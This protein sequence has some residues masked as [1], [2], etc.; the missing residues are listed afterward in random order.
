[1]K[2]VFFNSIGRKFIETMVLLFLPFYTICQVIQPGTIEYLKYSNGVNGIRLGADLGSINS[3]EI[4]FLDGNSNLD[5]DSCLNFECRDTSMLKISNDISLDLIGIRTYKNK[6]INIYLFFPR[7]SS[8]KILYDFLVSYGNFTYRP[9]SYNDIY[10][11]DSSAVS[12]SLLYEAK[13]DMGVAIFTCNQLNKA[14]LADKLKN[15][16]KALANNDLNYSQVD[17]ISVP[18]KVSN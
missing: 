6:I 7:V 4:A 12:L 18:G 5:V 15:A 17:N 10:Y 14:M 8:Y 9:S 2:T 13:V 16:N 11:W 1:M 3:K